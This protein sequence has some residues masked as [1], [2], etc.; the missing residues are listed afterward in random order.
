MIDSSIIKNLDIIK[1]NCLVF[2]IECSS[3]Y[4]TGQEINISDFTNYAKYA[5]VKWVGL[6][7]F[8]YNKEFLL[9]AAT[10]T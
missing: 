10:D 5:K 7:S 8:L 6:Y 1:S 4:P 2:D 9:N 3:K